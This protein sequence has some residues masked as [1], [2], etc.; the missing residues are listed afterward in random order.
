[1]GDCREGCVKYDGVINVPLV[2]V[3]Q[4]LVPLESP[5]K[6]LSNGGRIIENGSV[7]REICVNVV[8]QIGNR[9]VAVAVAAEWQWLG[10]SGWYRW[11]EEIET[12]RMAVVSWRGGGCCGSGS[13]WHVFCI[14]DFRLFFLLGTHNSIYLFFPIFPSKFP[15]FSHFPIKFLIFPIFLSN[16][17]FFPHFLIKITHFPIKNASKLPMFPSKTP[18]FLSKT[19]HFPIKISYLN[20]QLRWRVG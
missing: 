16:S 13:G 10:G 8:C 3:W 9:C 2:V 11:K 1:M 4:W 18:I 17:S 6:G 15:F 12:V 19:P 14:Y 7:L 20:P 5:F